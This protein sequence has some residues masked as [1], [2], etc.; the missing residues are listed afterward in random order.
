MELHPRSFQD[1]IKSFANVADE[2]ILAFDPSSPR[3]VASHS[4]VDLGDPYE[5]EA[6]YS[7]HLLAE[8]PRAAI[9]EALTNPQALVECFK[10]FPEVG[11][12][13]ASGDAIWQ[14]GPDWIIVKASLI[15]EDDT[16]A[17]NIVFVTLGIRE[18]SDGWAAFIWGP[19]HSSFAEV[20]GLDHWP[21][22]GWNFAV[23]SHGD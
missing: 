2:H 3:A 7:L 4:Y 1:L 21:T 16:K 9:P 15:H 12:F 17:E 19:G 22:D 14:N 8:D 11:I 6:T 5:D 23:V 20:F 18:V 10:T 13:N